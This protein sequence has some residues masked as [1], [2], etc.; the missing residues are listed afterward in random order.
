M[1]MKWKIFYINGDTFSNENGNP[2]DAPGGGVLAVVQEDESVGVLVHQG[3]TFYVFDNHYGG[4][5][6]LDRIGFVQYILRPGYKIIKVGE[7]MSTSRYK[8]M[9]ADIRKDPN[10]PNKSARYHWEN[11]L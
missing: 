3:N 9:I 7:S 8:E 4:W 11:T 10:L 6:G 1:I 5:Y 2:E